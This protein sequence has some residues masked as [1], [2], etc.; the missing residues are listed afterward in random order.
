MSGGPGGCTCGSLQVGAEGPAGSSLPCTLPQAGSG[1][2][3]PQ[4]NSRCPTPLPRLPVTWNSRPQQAQP[5]L[6]GIRRGGHLVA[7]S[8]VGPRQ[9]AAGPAARRLGAWFHQAQ[10]PTGR[11][12]PADSRQG[13]PGFPRPAWPSP[14]H[15]PDANARAGALHE[16]RVWHLPLRRPR[17]P[18]ADV[19][20]REFWRV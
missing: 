12:A 3:A 19:W 15:L 13:K 1:A 5:E 9:W 20:R 2:P 18:S 17:S 6:P 16:E 7:H 11:K 8:N 14:P 4:A 10:H